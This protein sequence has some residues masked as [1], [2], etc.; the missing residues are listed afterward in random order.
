VKKTDLLN[1][2]LLS[3]HRHLQHSSCCPPTTTNLP[4]LPVSL[5]LQKENGFFV[6]VFIIFL[7]KCLWRESLPLMRKNRFPLRKGESHVD[8]WSSS[9]VAQLH[10]TQ[11]HFSGSTGSASSSVV[12][13]DTSIPIYSYRDWASKQGSHNTGT[14]CIVSYQRCA[15]DWRPSGISQDVYEQQGCSTGWPPEQYIRHGCTQCFPR[16][17]RLQNLEQSRHNNPDTAGRM[18]SRDRDGHNTINQR[19][20]L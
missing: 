12:V 11:P 9:S 4:A 20:G 19:A 15:E 1:P 10:Q 5:L 13:M 8:K 2:G 16:L 17:C 18:F 7:P 3:Q 6:F 14:H